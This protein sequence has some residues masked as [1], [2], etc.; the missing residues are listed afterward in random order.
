MPGR[1]PL[2]GPR[3]VYFVGLSTAA[4]VFPYLCVPVL[5]GICAVPLFTN[6]FL[7][8]IIL[9]A[10]LVTH[11]SRLTPHDVGEGS[12]RLCPIVYAT[13]VH[14]L[15]PSSRMPLQSIPDAAWLTMFSSRAR[16]NALAVDRLD[17][18]SGPRP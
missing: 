15:A 17:S 12:Q 13:A 11:F 16:D 7:Q 18:V 14:C 8:E 4:L 3:L 6:S 10:S 9:P 1:G 5:A 2:V